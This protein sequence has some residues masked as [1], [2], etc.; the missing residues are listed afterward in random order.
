[1][2]REPD[3]F[4]RGVALGVLAGVLLVVFLTPIS[5]P[6]LRGRVRGSIERWQARIWD[7]LDRLEKGQQHAAPPR[8]GT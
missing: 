5:G 2:Q 6:R 8:L 7:A 3:W 1:M 4:W